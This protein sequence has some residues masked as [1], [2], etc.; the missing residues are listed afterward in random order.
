M[1]KG[2][3]ILALLDIEKLKYSYSNKDSDAFSLE[4]DEWKVDEGEFVSLLGP[5]GCGKSTLL[6]LISRLIEPISGRIKFSGLDIV[7][8]PHKEYAK[9]V[10]YVSQ[11]TY[12]LFPF[13]VYEIVMM[14]RTPYL[15]TLGF[16]SSEDRRIVNDALEAM[17]IT[18]LKSKGINEI[19]GGE[20]QR[21]YIAR[22]LAQKPKLILLDE[23]NAHLDIEHQISIFELLIQL[24]KDTNLSVISVSHDLNLIGIFSNEIAFMV[25][26]RITLKGK[27]KEVLTQEN[28]KQIFNVDS[29]VF[30]SKEEDTT[31]ILINPLNKNLEIN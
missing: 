10:A 2:F 7:E 1:E 26:G 23:P 25:D 9:L 13:S 6:K 22:A 17:E 8:F 18:H 27:K 31:N 11:N 15:G 21:A 24:N 12:S 4:I 28:I 14:G 20:A 29:T 16:E 19:S 30:Y 3:I 5:N